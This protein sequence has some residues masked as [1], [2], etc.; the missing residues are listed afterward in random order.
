LY[1]ALEILQEHAHWAALLASAQ[2]DPSGESGLVTTLQLESDTE[3]SSSRLRLSTL[4][5]E[6]DMVINAQLRHR[7]GWQL[8]AQA[9]SLK[10]RISTNLP[11]DKAHTFAES[12]N[13]CAQLG[14]LVNDLLA[15]TRTLQ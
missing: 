5:S 14:G 1:A 15:W 9:V 4:V 3:P 13:M 10:Q 8:Q 2:E 11:D 6:Q 7:K 12:L